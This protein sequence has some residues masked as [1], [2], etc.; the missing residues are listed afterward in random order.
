M[1]VSTVDLEEAAS[2]AM[3]REKEF[4]DSLAEPA[5]WLES[6]QEGARPPSRYQGLLQ[7]DP[8]LKRYS[9]A[10]EEALKD[11]SYAMPRMKVE[12]SSYQSLLKDQQ[13]SLRQSHAE[14]SADSCLHIESKYFLPLPTNYP[15]YDILP[16]IL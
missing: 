15:W 8:K 4:E 16:V 6:S 13:V 10:S 2:T 9:N 1:S 11:A 5:T 12:E 3:D 7:A 14:Y